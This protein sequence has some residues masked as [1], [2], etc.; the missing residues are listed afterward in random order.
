MSIIG[1]S[2]AKINAEKNEGVKGR[3]NIKNNITVKN[4]SAHALA[5]GGKDNKGLR[6]DFE[7]ESV[8]E[9]KLGKIVIESN[10][11]SMLPEK[12]VDKINSEWKK[13]KVLPDELMRS[14]FGFVMRKCSIKALNLAE[15]LNLP[16]P[17]PMPRVAS[18]PGPEPQKETAKK[19]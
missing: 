9:P 17:V 14:M 11:M 7:Y 19:A 12:E 13:S 18:G 1:F 8:Y 2:F 10:I 3:I 15:D 6:I 16:S 4:V 5:F